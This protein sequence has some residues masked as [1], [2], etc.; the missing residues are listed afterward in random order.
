MANSYGTVQIRLSAA[1]MNGATSQG[2]MNLGIREDVKKTE[3][4]FEDL[5]KRHVREK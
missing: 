2:L 4:R 1:D 5:F 3:G